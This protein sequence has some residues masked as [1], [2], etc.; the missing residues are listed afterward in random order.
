MLRADQTIELYDPNGTARA[1]VVPDPGTRI[2]ALIGRAGRTLAIIG[3]HHQA[4]VWTDDATFAVLGTGGLTRFDATTGKLLAARCGWRFG[5]S[6]K[7]HPISAQVE[8]ICAQLR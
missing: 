5:K 1:R 7:P 2:A 3:D 6:S 4:Y 8:P